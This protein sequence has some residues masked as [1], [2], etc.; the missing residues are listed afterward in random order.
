MDTATKHAQKTALKIKE[1]ISG[2]SGK[3]DK[4]NSYK[5]NKS[6]K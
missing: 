1:E 5:C 2:K 3:N 6:R 4:N